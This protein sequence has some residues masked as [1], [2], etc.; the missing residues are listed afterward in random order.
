MHFRVSLH[1]LFIR[2]P[3]AITF[4]R[5]HGATGLKCVAFTYLFQHT[6]QPTELSPGVQY[7]TGKHRIRG[8]V[9][10]SA[11]EDSYRLIQV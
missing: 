5:H 3:F 2:I 6:A 8:D 9:A 7:Q 11:E 10:S 4:E 1:F